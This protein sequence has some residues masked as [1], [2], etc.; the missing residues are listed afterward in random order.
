MSEL[1]LQFLEVLVKGSLAVCP[2]HVASVMPA[3]VAWDPRR[4]EQKVDHLRRK[5]LSGDYSTV[6]AAGMFR[7]LQRRPATKAQV[8]LSPM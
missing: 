7:V 4:M 3:T 6:S 2:A 5:C 1:Q 8:G